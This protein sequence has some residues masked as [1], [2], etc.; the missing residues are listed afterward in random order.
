[1]TKHT[2]LDDGYRTRLAAGGSIGRY[3][4]RILDS[5]LDS[6]SST[7]SPRSRSARGTAACTTR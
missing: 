4:S 3:V 1:V 2:T 7:S 6:F 5:Y